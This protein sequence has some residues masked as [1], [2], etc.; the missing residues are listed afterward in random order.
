VF[1]IDTQQN[2]ADA[3]VVNF[4]FCDTEISRILTKKGLLSIT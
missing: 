2:K 1:F 3:V 4:I